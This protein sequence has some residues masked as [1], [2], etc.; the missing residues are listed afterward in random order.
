[1]ARKGLGGHHGYDQSRNALEILEKG[2]VLDP[3]KRWARASY[4]RDGPCTEGLK[5]LHLGYE[6]KDLLKAGY[7]QA[8]LCGEGGGNARRA[9]S[10][11]GGHR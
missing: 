1:M 2:G 7:Q 3:A 5:L 9:A 10:G 8:E 4:L 6:V 11:A